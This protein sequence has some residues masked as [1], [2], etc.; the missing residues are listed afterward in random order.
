M[1]KYLLDTNVAS[2][3]IKG[4]FPT[5]RK[6]LARVPIEQLGISVI[7]EAELRYGL[8]RRPEATRLK[9]LVD[10]FLLRVT[11]LTWDSRTAQT[12][13]DLRAT[14]EHARQPMDNL[15]LMIASHALSIPATLVTNDQVFSRIKGLKI[16]NW[17]KP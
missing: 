12:Y 13:A 16:V 14:L 10:E 6:H 4:V 17:A 2:Y 3:V 11:I 9:M 1:I 7:T 15:D 5:I 8:A